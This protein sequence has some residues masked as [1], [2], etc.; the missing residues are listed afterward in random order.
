MTL[1]VFTAGR[2]R[3]REIVYVVSIVNAF[4]HVETSGEAGGE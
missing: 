4:G 3:K 1:V 2:E